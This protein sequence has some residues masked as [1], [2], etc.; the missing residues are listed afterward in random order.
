MMRKRRFDR[1]SLKCTEGAFW[2]TVEGF[3]RFGGWVRTAFRSA[4]ASSH[5]QCLPHTI[6]ILTTKRPAMLTTFALLSC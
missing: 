1:A 4:S 2:L 5:Y 3:A 6:C